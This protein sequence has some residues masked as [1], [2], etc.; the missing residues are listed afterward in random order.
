MACCL[1][2]ALLVLAAPLLA[3]EPDPT[4]AVADG[5]SI[6]ESDLRISGQVRKLEQQIYDL[7]L[8]AVQDQIGRR[9]AEKAAAARNMTLD[10]MLQQDVDSKVPDPTPQE[11]EAF[12][13]GQRDRI[14]QPLDAIR[15]QVAAALKSLKIRES[16]QA[17]LDGFRQR[18]QV[19][20]LL[21]PPKLTV[22]I[23]NAPRRGPA[24]A[25]VT[26]IEFSDF[27]CPYCRRAQ[28]TLSELFSRYPDQISL[29]HKDMPLAE[30]HPEAQSAAEAA[31]CAGEQGK[32][33]EYHDALFALPS[34]SS[35]AYEQ[36]AQSLQLDAPKFR[37]CLDSHRYLSQIRAD[38]DEAQSLG[39]ASTPTFIINGTVL[40]GAQPTVAFSR[41]IDAE[42][43][44]LKATAR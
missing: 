19:T 22:E 4:L 1:K 31:R 23:G 26:I 40:E 43:A 39:V 6:R 5:T 13:L 15:S 44:A 7:K 28:A 30:I 38:A 36:A 16:R 20:I 21:R 3:Q 24:A 12:Y 35:A 8:Q 32:F 9:L 33:W 25:P 27:Q 18:A 2:L 34:L 42:L 29:A 37:A 41:L 17:Y 10:A 14:N 11:V